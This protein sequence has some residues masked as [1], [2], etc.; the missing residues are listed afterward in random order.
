MA[1]TIMIST[2]VKPLWK[3]RLW[4]IGNV[5]KKN[6]KYRLFII[7]IL[8]I[9]LYWPSAV[10]TITEFYFRLFALGFRLSGRINKK[11]G[12]FYHRLIIIKES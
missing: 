4:L 9:L 5:F 11:G 8:L 2:K 12:G 10:N 6:E 7:C 1:M 3:I